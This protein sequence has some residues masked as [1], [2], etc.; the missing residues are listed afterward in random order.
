MSNYFWVFIGGGLG[1]IC[2]YG[3]AQLLSN[4][5]LR[6]PWATFLANALACIIL[7]VLTGL[8]LNNQIPQINYRMLLMTGFCGGFS[9][10]STFSNETFLLL[11]AGHYFY[12]IA[13]ILLSL[14]ICLLCIYAGIKLVN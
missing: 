12:A 14:T 13:N 6:F 5:A 9:T 7:G 4:Y 3:V 8:T 2:R 11:H 1:S 10:F